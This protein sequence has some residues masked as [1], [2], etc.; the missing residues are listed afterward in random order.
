MQSFKRHHYQ[1]ITKTVLFPCFFFT[2]ITS[3]LTSKSIIN[4]PPKKSLRFWK[5]YV[6]NVY[7]YFRS[8]ILHRIWKAYITYSSK[9]ISFLKFDFLECVCPTKTIP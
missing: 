3:I 6:W 1:H 8:I 9:D 5:D 2:I 7:E 4:L